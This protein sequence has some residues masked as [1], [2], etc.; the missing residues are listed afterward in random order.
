M[1]SEDLGLEG[2]TVYHNAGRRQS[3]NH[4]S[5]RRRTDNHDFDRGRSGDLRDDTER[6]DIHDPDHVRAGGGVV[7]GN[8]DLA[9]RRRS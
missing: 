2:R 6:A 3:D 4:T 1:R 7:R 8:A 5:G 9:R